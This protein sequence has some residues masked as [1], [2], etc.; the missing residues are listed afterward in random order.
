MVSVLGPIE[1]LQKDMEEA[2]MEYKQA[3]SYNLRVVINPTSSVKKIIEKDWTLPEVVRT[4]AATGR[5]IAIQEERSILGIKLYRTVVALAYPYGTYSNVGEC[6][7]V[8][9]EDYI[10]L[11]AR[12]RRK[13]SEREKRAID[14]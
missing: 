4:H 5:E 2:V 9:D 6:V 12:V 1:S 3:T 8:A 10:L 11:G 14:L 13:I 7:I